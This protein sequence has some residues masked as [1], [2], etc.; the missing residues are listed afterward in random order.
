MF[1]VVGFVVV[2]V[3]ADV[4]INVV[5]EMLRRL[6]RVGVLPDGLEGVAISDAI[7]AGRL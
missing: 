3:I 5:G 1:V 6:L 4:V 7:M 2:E